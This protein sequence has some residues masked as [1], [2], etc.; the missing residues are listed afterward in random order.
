MKIEHSA[1]LTIKHDTSVGQLLEALQGAQVPESA[2]ITVDH[3]AGDQR[4]PSY[5]HLKF[6][7]ETGS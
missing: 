6:K 5:T 1:Q 3:W 2:K 4:D 7:W